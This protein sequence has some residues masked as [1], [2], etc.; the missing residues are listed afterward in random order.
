MVCSVAKVVP[1]PVLTVMFAVPPFS[2]ID[3]SSTEKTSAGTPSSSVMVSVC[4]DP[5]S[6]DDLEALIN[7]VSSASWMRSSTPVT[8]T[9]TLDACAPEPAGSASVFEPMV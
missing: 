1:V 9:V 4:C 7:M 6:T 8:V 2:A 5:M 3:A